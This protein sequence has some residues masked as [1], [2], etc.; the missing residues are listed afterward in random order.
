[1]FLVISV[2]MFFI[3]LLL[4]TVFVEASVQSKLTSE[5]SHI[6]AVTSEKEN[7]SYIL[8]DKNGNVIS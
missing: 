4:M 5:Y 8:R 3:M 6:M 7:W 1:M 2:M